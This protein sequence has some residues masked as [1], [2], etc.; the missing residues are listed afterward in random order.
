MVVPCIQL[1][2]TQTHKVHTCTQV[3]LSE[4]LCFTVCAAVM[5]NWTRS[6]AA[7]YSVHGGGM[8]EHG[9]SSRKLATYPTHNSQ[10][11]WACTENH[12]ALPLH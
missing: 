7:V 1:V 4:V 9:Y 11:R 12:L 8:G 3:L 2:Y 5:C 6:S 10:A